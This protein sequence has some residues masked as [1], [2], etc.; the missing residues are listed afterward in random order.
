VISRQLA[1]TSY[2]CRRTIGWSKPSVSPGDFEQAEK[3]VSGEQTCGVDWVGIALMAALLVVACGG[4]V[5]VAKLGINFGRGSPKPTR[6]RR[7]NGDYQP[8]EPPEERYW[9]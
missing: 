6:I 4:I 1:V 9:G 5:L 3:Q 7:A 2:Q 8:P